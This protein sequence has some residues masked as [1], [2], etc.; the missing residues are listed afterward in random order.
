MSSDLHAQDGARRY[1]ASLSDEP[2]AFSDCT[3]RVEEVEARVPGV[4]FARHPNGDVV[5]FG[6]VPEQATGTYRGMA[7]YYRF[8]SNTA[9]LTV[10]PQQVEQDTITSHDHPPMTVGPALCSTMQQVTDEDMA[11]ALPHHIGAQVLVNLFETL[12]EPSPD[13]TYL[14]RMAARLDF[15]GGD[16]VAAMKALLPEARHV[17]ISDLREAAA[18]TFYRLPSGS[19]LEV[20]VEPDLGDGLPTLT[21]RGYTPQAR[22]FALGDASLRAAVTLTGRSPA[23][24]RECVLGGLKELDDETCYANHTSRLDPP[25]RRARQETALALLDEISAMCPQVPRLAEPE[26]KAMLARS[27]RDVVDMLLGR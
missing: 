26:R 15:D 10:W 1:L 27:T 25:E 6:M 2:R 13:E 16:V 17:R 9:T 14:G 24:V 18:L 22:P 3:A 12:H 4:E 8:R 23:E 21:M 19:A 20:H 7:F 5:G 11:G